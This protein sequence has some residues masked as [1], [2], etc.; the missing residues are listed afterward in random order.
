M[1]CI[2][3][4]VAATALLM[5][6]ASCGKDDP[7]D[8]DDPSGKDDPVQVSEVTLNKETLVLTVDGSE[9]L[10][11][12]IKPDNAADKTITWTSS[13][14][15][16]ASVDA[17]TGEVTARAEGKATVMATSA[18]GKIAGCE[19]TVVAAVVEIESITLDKTELTLAVG[20][21]ETLTATVTPDN[22]ADETL[23][24]TSSASGVASV[25]ASTGEVTAVAK[26]E[27][28]ITA[29][30]ANGKE[31]TCEITVDY[32]VETVL[33]PK[34][35]FLMGSSDGSAVGSGTP[36]TD[37]NA[38]P[39]EPGR[40]GDETQHRVTLSRDYYMSKYPVTNAQYAAFLNA[41]EIDETGAKAGIQKGETL[42]STN[43]GPED[44]DLHYSDGRWGT[45]GGYENHPVI[46]VSWYGAKAFA[47]WAGG[48]LP[49]EAQWER[50]ARGGIENM[51]FGIGNGKVLTGAMANIN[52]RYPYDFDRG[53]SY[54]D[55]NGVHAEGTTA[56]GSYPDYANA[57][58]LYDMH[59]NV[60]EWC[61]DKWDSNDNYAGLSATDPLCDTGTYRMLRGGY[62]G[63]NAQ[64]CRSAYRFG[65]S[66]DYRHDS[67]GF[68]VVFPPVHPE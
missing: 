7:A 17:S 18:N 31:A 32:I 13:A 21:S 48:D 59:G 10:T 14:S 25:D 11:A 47:E 20:G 65:N 36:G 57:Y 5:M 8:K 51:P 63:F 43:G 27:A 46:Y 30:T 6:A 38:T 61:L 29:T 41:M 40:Y 19:I 15:G 67:A 16:V 52:G 3:L 42:V 4:L 56:V 33:I 45:V 55:G 12:T 68:R 2:K 50:A 66:P 9:T 60:F 23:T 1:R 28:I 62:R 34:G 35:T 39:A 53:G 44:W 49:T 26:G 24:W 54:N 22:A 64:Y 37:P 58:G